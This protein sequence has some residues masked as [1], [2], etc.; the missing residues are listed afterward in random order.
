M[1][2]EMFIHPNALDKV[3]RPVLV[4][5]VSLFDHLPEPGLDLLSGDCIEA[6]DP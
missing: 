5:L 3:Y 4:L 2:M 1:N 6:V